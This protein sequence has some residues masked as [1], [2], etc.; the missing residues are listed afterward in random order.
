M[1][2]I[3]EKISNLGGRINKSHPELITIY[4]QI[5]LKNLQK[6]IFFMYL[7]VKSVSNL[8]GLTQKVIMPTMRLV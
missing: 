6:V 7:I 8:I 2:E 3:S 4:V 1:R 5:F